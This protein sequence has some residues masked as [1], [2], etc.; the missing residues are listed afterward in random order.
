LELE[1]YQQANDTPQSQSG[2]LALAPLVSVVVPSFNR[3]KY[4]KTTLE[5][6]L[7]QDYPHIECI[8]VDA[9]STDGTFD[10]LQTLAG[11]IEWICEP[12]GGPPDAINKGWRI[13]R[14]DILT[15]LNADDLWEKGAVSK[16]VKCF[17]ENPKAD[18]VYG[19]YGVIDENGKRVSTRIKVKE[20]NLL[21]AVETCDHII[22]QAASFMRRPILE[23]VGFLYP[24]LCHDHE[25]WL[26]L[27]LA[28]AKFQKLDEVLG[29]P[30]RW[31]GNL[32]ASSELVIPLK[33]G[34]TKNF[35]SLPGVPPS[36]MGIKKRAMSNAHLR[37]IDYVRVDSLTPAVQASKIKWLT[38]EAHKADP[39]NVAA[40]NY[41]KPLMPNSVNTPSH[42]KVANFSKRGSG[43]LL[44]VP[45]NP[46][47]EMVSD[48]APAHWDRIRWPMTAYPKGYDF[49][50]LFCEQRTLK[51]LDRPYLEKQ[52][53]CRIIP[54]TF[55]AVREPA[56]LVEKLGGAPVVTMDVPLPDATWL[57]TPINEKL[58]QPRARKTIECLFLGRIQYYKDR[59][60]WRDGKLSRVTFI[61]R[62]DKI[63]YTS[64]AKMLSSA[65]TIVNFRADRTNGRAAMKGRVFEALMAGAVLLEQENG[66]TRQWLTPG[67]DYLEWSTPTDIDIHLKGLRT[68]PDYAAKLLS[69]AAMKA[70]EYSAKN[71]WDQ[72]VELAK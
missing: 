70:R 3:L 44:I 20:W 61:E 34:I 22:A 63:P 65:R 68:N 5:S 60:E 7:S 55:D 42:W 37:C 36:M 1:S 14:G 46:G 50:V 52:L 71:C 72:I 47:Y 19:D 12:D 13:A 67:E 53:G 59:R 9:E 38:E 16:A 56:N 64:Y 24:K 28:G 58:Y 32:G 26:R 29:L 66:W 31:A 15:W 2:N 41:K 6:I 49:A 40:A 30:R 10:Y 18:V 33:L 21:H 57:W 17:I 48:T 11:K 45:G 25:L 51:V 69:N 27:A 35:F 4:L 8:V 43:P 62:D 39:T 23:K 54:V